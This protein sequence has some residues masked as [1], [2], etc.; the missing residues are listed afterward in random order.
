MDALLYINQV[1]EQILNYHSTSTSMLDLRF[2]GSK[3]LANALVGHSNA[4]RRLS[5]L[6]H[7]CMYDVMPWP[8]DQWKPLK[9]GQAFTIEPLLLEAGGVPRGKVM[10]G[11]G[12]QISL[13]PQFESCDILCF[14]TGGGG[15]HNPE[16]CRS[17]VN[18]DLLICAGVARPVD[19]GQRGWLA[20]CTV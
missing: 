15:Y 2:P 4:L 16:A 1:V 7:T 5:F 8:A 19:H 11:V 10:R 18:N 6:E 17:A 12:L 3:P 20:Q 9:A 13:V 14:L